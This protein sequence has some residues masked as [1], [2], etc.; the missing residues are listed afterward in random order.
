MINRDNYPAFFLDY[1]EGNLPEDRTAELWQFLDDHPDLREEFDAFEMITLEGDD[2]VS[3]PGKG[4]LKKSE[5][6]H[7]YTRPQ[8]H[9][10][11]LEIGPDNYEELFAAYVEGDLATADA[12]AVEAFAGSSDILQ[13][14]L[15]LMQKARLE[16]DQDIV[17]P[18]KGALKRHPLGGIRRQVLWYSSA[19]AAV[20]LMAVMVYSLF[21]VVEEP[22]YAYELPVE[23]E[24]D[25]PEAVAAD[26]SPQQEIAPDTRMDQPAVPAQTD[27][28]RQ[29]IPTRLADAEAPARRQIID[30]GLTGRPLLA[31]LMESRSK[32]VTATRAATAPETMESRMELSW[33]AYRDDMNMPALATLG[34]DDIIVED[35][36]AGAV[37]ETGRRELDVSL[38]R[39]AMNRLEETSGIDFQRVEEIVTSDR[40]NVL[41]LAGRSLA[42]L[43]NLAGRPVVVDGETNA[44]GRRVQFA[45]GNFF[46]VSRSGNDD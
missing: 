27:T 41:E 34:Q 8:L 2:S 16:P 6:D 44:Q 28:R 36:T 23:G 29:T 32:G 26:P 21:P 22:R 35:E 9:K 15:D 3:F 19:A 4:S 13:R 18:R 46:E 17:F 42:G 11:Q 25:V 31:G 45:I 7:L 39:L 38:T 20:L 12:A 37:V 24:G 14:E 40:F 5:E 43:N 33:M 1:H 10:K 30:S